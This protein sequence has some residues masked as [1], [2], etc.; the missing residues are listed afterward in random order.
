M[1]NILTSFKDGNPQ[2]STQSY[3]QFIAAAKA[4]TGIVATWDGARVILPQDAR[5]FGEADQYVR[6]RRVVFVNVPEGSAPP[7]PV[8]AEVRDHGS[9]TW[10]DFTAYDTQN[11]CVEGQR[12][13]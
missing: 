4:N 9:Y 10:Y 8:Y 7:R 2:P 13:I 6:I 5:A 12:A 11:V 3:A 1:E